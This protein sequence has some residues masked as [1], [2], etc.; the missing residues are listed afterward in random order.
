MA[1]A[2]AWTS[3]SLRSA[4]R[5]SALTVGAVNAVGFCVTAATHTHK[6]TDLAGTSAFVGSAWATWTAAATAGR[7]PLVSWTRGFGVTAVVTAWG[8]RLGGYLLSRVLKVG[9]DSRLD[10]FF[11]KPGE[12]PLKLA[13]FWTAQAAWGFVCML[14]VTAAHATLPAATRVGLGGGLALAVAAAALGVQAAAD[15]QK[16]RWKR[17]HPDAPLTTGLYA[18]VQYPN[19]ASEIAFWTAVTAAAGPTALAAAPFAAASPAFSAVLLS[20]VSGVPPLDASRRARYGSDP[21]F[22]AYYESTPRLLP[23]W[24]GGK[25]PVW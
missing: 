12:L 11:P 13:G 21:A 14:P 1:A 6:V 20:R 9:S 15:D 17:D 16:G 19:Y 22:R 5:L 4:L 3:T 10:P 18:T 8:A 23:K 7:V 24:A 2:P 25:A